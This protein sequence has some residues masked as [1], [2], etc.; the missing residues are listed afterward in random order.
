M[1]SEVGRVN[2]NLANIFQG[3]RA[4]RAFFLG[5]EISLD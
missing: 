1:P 4:P 3:S 5:T 2:K